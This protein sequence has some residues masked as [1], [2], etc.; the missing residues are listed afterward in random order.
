MYSSTFVRHQSTALLVAQGNVHHTI[1]T[2]QFS[3]N[4]GFWLY[5]LKRAFGHRRLSRDCQS[6]QSRQVAVPHFKLGLT[7]GEIS[8]SLNSQNGLPTANCLSCDPSLNAS[9]QCGNIVA[10]LKLRTAR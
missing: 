4:K 7:S 10:Y 9:C 3:R 8:F 1:I 6:P 5:T 2:L